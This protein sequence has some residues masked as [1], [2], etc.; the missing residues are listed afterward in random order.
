MLYTVIGKPGEGKSYW[1]VSQMYEKQQ[2]N[3]A[4]LKKNVEVYYENKSILADRGHDIDSNDEYTFKREINI[5]ENG[6]IVAK[7]VD[8]TFQY[9]EFQE[10]EDEEQFEKY[11][12]LAMLY[13]DFIAH[14]NQLYT[15]TLATFLPVRQIYSD[16]NGLKIE[17]VLPLPSLDWRETPDGSIMY[18]D[19]CRKK[20]PYKFVS[21]TPSKDPIIIDM[22][23]VRHY[24]KDVYL[25]SQDAEDINNSLRQLVDKL[26]FIKR[27]SQKPQACSLYTFDKWL[28]RPRAAADSTKEPKPYVEYELIVYKKKYFKM[29]KSASS[30]TSMKFS[31]NW[32]IFGWILLTFGL[33]GIVAYGLNKVPIFGQFSDVFKQMV[34]LEKSPFEDVSKLGSSNIAEQQHSQPQQ[35]STTDNPVAASESTGSNATNDSNRQIEYKYDVRRPYDFEYDLT[36]QIH[37]R[38]RL[39]GCIASRNTC[40]C[41]TQ[42][43]TKIDMSQSDCK[44]YMSGDKPFDYFTKQQ[45][46]Q[47]QHVQLQQ[48]YTQKAGTQQATDFDREYFA[49]LEQAKQQGLI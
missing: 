45:E 21:K 23:E 22:A 33:M 25:I 36:Y 1:C 35:Q 30:H 6:L 42:Q 9:N 39:A 10:F 12:E 47:R 41:Y 24:D 38:P 28:G 4:N 8:W 19:E 48:T 14:I 32:K 31:L 3:L 18:I 17:G 27:P 34:G 15:I 7:I 5:K 29:Y 40:S 43:A 49:K 20:P 26:Y 44:R 16:I 13:N 46:Q 2:V 37:E 11:F